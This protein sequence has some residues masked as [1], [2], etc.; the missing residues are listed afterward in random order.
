MTIYLAYISAFFAIPA[1]AYALYK[2]LRHQI[3]GRAIKITFVRHI[4]VIAVYAVGMQYTI[5]AT[6]Y[7]VKPEDYVDINESY[8]GFLKILNMLI[9]YMLFIVQCCEPYWFYVVFWKGY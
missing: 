1:I 2:F 7:G 4:L 3:N 6:I 8:Y 9:G 5:A